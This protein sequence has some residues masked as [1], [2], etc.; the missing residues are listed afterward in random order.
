MV[1]AGA[2]RARRA[3]RRAFFPMG[4][5]P[6]HNRSGRDPGA[7]GRIPVHLWLPL[8]VRRTALSQ[9]RPIDRK[10]RPGAQRG[11]CGGGIEMDTCYAAPQ[12]GGADGAK[13]EVRTEEFPFRSNPLERM[14]VLLSRRPRRQ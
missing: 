5:G 13:R 6:S 2:A 10:P 11:L 8:R 9:D 4:T 3:F 7:L 14:V 12:G 1:L